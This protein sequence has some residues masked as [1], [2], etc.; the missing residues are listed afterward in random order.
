MLA[1][2]IP[3]G[4]RRRSAETKMNINITDRMISLFLSGII[5]VLVLI[6]VGAILSV[7]FKKIDKK[8]VFTRMALI[9]ALSPLTLVHFL[10]ESSASTLYLFA[11]VAVLLGIAI[12]GINHLLL[13][14]ELP[15]EVTKAE[16]EVATEAEENEAATETEPSVIVWEKAE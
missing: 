12:D 11:M 2:H 10:G 9:V 14:K 15:R 8:F 1:C 16:S 7:V 5:S 6:V 4:G 13:P 3:K